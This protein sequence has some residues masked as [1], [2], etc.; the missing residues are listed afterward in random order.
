[1]ERHH[2]PV[3]TQWEARERPICLTTSSATPS[4]DRNAD[5]RPFLGS[6]E[7][8]TSI[9]DRISSTKHGELKLSFEDRPECDVG[10][11]KGRVTATKV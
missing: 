8:K 4:G 2:V 5:D 7:M 11:D 10:C 3:V 1:M 9:C 6:R